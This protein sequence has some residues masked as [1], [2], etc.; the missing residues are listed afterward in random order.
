MI[1]IFLSGDKTYTSNGEVVLT[2][3]KC[4]V[5]N[6]D[7]GEFTLEVTSPLKYVDYLVCNNIIVAPTPSGDQPFRIYDVKKQLQK[8]TA[9]AKHI[10]FDMENYVIADSYAVNKT[11][12]QA[13]V[14]FKNA[15]DNPTPFT[16]YSDIATLDNL[17]IVRKSLEQALEEVNE[18]WGGHIIRD[19]F[20]VE[21]NAKIGVDNG[22]TIEYG[23]NLQELTAEYNFTDT[24]TKIL[25]VG[26]DGLLL[27]Q[28]YVS[29]PISYEIPFSKVIEFQQDLEQEDYATENEYI[30]AL[31]RDL[32]K[33]ATAYVN[34]HCYPTVT[35]TLKGKPEKV[36]NIGDIIRVRDKRLG[37]DLVTQVISYEYDPVAGKYN[38][39][40]F[41]NF[42]ES[43]NSKLN[44]K[45]S[46]IVRS[47]T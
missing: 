9:K 13:L 34:E 10:T 30:Y 19:G 3:S 45:I 47:M 39:L 1:K 37:I 29:A 38:S 23:K 44:K 36:S 32:L 22:I 21:N 25:P 15:T 46:E 24:A 7:N 16:F 35:Y 18:R 2:S 26:R 11:C 12:Q 33:Q 40:V 27:D 42:A 6:S 8:V 41:G 43:I 28:L 20:R 17:R 5:N 14:H 31:K 4:K